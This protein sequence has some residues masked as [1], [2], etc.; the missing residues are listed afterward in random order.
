MPDRS[1]V[2]FDITLRTLAGGRYRV[3]SDTSGSHDE[4]EL[5]LPFDDA[6]R[7]EIRDLVQGPA[8]DLGAAAPASLGEHV[9]YWE[10]VKIIGERLYDAVFVDGVAASFR[11][12]RDRARQLPEAPIVRIRLH[13]DETPELAD[14]PWEYLYK[15]QNFLVLGERTPIVRHVN[16]PNPAPQPLVKPPVSMLIMIAQGNPPLDVQKE[17]QLIKETLKPLE[18]RKI[19]SLNSVPANK[20]ALVDALVKNNRHHI[21]HFIGHSGFI[22]GGNP[23]QKKPVL[24]LDDGDIE[25]AYLTT[26]LDPNSLRLVVLNSCDGARPAA[27]DAFTALASSFIRLGIMAVVAM[28]FKITDVA[29]IAFASGL[30]GGIAD[31][32][33]IEESVSRGRAAIFGKDNNPTEWGTPV[34]FAHGTDS[35]LFLFDISAE[36]QAQRDQVERLAQQAKRAIDLNQ[37]EIAISKLKKASELFAELLEAN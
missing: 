22:E 9:D 7:A 15:G 20:K 23:A 3:A 4:A 37:Y 5:K 2:D 11:S 19:L 18:D 21:F 24:Q 16:H 29:A 30:Y 17:W 13:L 10:K 12:C 32:E 28:Q 14:L 33:T 35:R 36:Q 34:L 8:R 31:R 6:E 1:Y 27:D 25:A 26:R